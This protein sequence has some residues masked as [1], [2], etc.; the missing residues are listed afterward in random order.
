MLHWTKK[1]GVDIEKESPCAHQEVSFGEDQSEIYRYKLQVW[2]RKIPDS[3]G[4]GCLHGTPQEGQEGIKSVLLFQL[5]AK[6]DF[7]RVPTGILTSC[8]FR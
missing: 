7:F 3:T 1:E 8:Y 6:I 5:L 4:Q 2:S